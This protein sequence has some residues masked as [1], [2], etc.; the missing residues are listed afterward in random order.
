MAYVKNFVR[1]SQTCVTQ[2]SKAL[3]RYALRR[4]GRKVTKTSAIEFPYLNEQ[5]LL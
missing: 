4:G 2:I 1:S 3:Y 5:L